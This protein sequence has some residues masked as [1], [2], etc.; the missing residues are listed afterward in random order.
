M[1]WTSC[2]EK[3]AALIY[4]MMEYT[5]KIDV[6]ALLN[7]AVTYCDRDTILKTLY[8]GADIMK[9]DSTQMLPLE[10]AIVNKNSKFLVIT[11][12]YCYF[13][14]CCGSETFCYYKS[15]SNFSKRFGSIF[16]SDF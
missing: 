1:T 5:E 13:Y 4:A 3:Q 10:V 11:K 16:G 9:A 15:G 14:Q 8:W 6:N 12:P 7:C 2:R